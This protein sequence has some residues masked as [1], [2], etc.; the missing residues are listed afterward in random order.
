[1]DG[2]LVLRRWSRG[3]EHVGMP[4]CNGTDT[5]GPV[6]VFMTHYGRCCQPKDNGAVL[7]DNG[8]ELRDGFRNG[9]Q[10]KMLVFGDEAD[11][12]REKDLF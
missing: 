10:D 8:L 2:E 3:A 9:V 4:S 1:M 6:L 11:E 5:V 12:K 7:L